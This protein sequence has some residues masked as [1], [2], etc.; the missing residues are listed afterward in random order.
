[1][2]ILK[3]FGIVAGI[4]AFALILIFT[5]P[6]CSSTDKPPAVAEAPAPPAAAPAPV[7]TV[8]IAPAPA[9]DPAPGGAAA[10]VTASPVTADASAS[11]ITLFNPTRPGTLAA[12]AL[13]KPAV[14]DVTP[15]STYVVGKGDSLWTIA[16]KNHVKVSDLTKVNNLHSGSSLHIGQRIIIP[17]AAGGQ[18]A[19]AR[20]PEPAP[21]FSAAA[22]S[23][24]T[25]PARYVVKRGESLGA[26]ARKFHV[27]VRD[28]AVANN[29]SDPQDIH[30]GQELTIPAGRGAAKASA[31]AAP[32][33][34]IGPEQDLDAGLKPAAPGDVPAIKVDD[35]APPPSVQPT[36]P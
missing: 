6:G 34:T 20:E 8:P 22:A 36:Q 18:G 23:G 5:N 4:H 13:E 1:M 26:I 32:A 11:G 7:I 35:S 14:T 21:T 17:G 12:A 3:I 33:L 10:A 2:K 24:A 9:L 19:A 15:A 25:A 16:K 31:P 29:I 27:R 28:L 30:A